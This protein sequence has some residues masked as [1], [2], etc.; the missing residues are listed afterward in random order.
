MRSV[1]DICVLLVTLLH[2]PAVLS[3][4]T[5]KFAR[6]CSSVRKVLV[7]TRL[8][9]LFG[10][11]FGDDLRRLFLVSEVEDPKIILIHVSATD[12]TSRV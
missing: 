5:R 11:L 9:P 3:L 1:R 6:H 12:H 8:S 10:F 4:S 7:A 2:T